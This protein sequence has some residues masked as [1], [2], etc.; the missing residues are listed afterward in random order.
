MKLKPA[1]KKR[2]NRRKP[3]VTSSKFDFTI[4]TNGLPKM[5][6]LKP[7][8]KVTVL[9]GGSSGS[10]QVRRVQPQGWD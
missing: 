8:P 2:T 9:G 7:N 6:V 10:E 3:L 4:A 1:K 5:P